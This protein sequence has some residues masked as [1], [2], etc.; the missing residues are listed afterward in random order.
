MFFLF[1]LSLSSGATLS[2]T[3]FFHVQTGWTFFFF[4]V[5][6]EFHNKIVQHNRIYRPVFFFSHL[7]VT[8]ALYATLIVLRSIKR[9][10]GKIGG[11]KRAKVHKT[12]HKSVG[13]R[14]DIFFAL[15]SVEQGFLKGRHDTEIHRILAEGHDIPTV[16]Q[17]NFLSE[18]AA[19]QLRGRR[20]A[21]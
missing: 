8:P 21:S 11:K 10:G 14:P 9:R 16:I 4:V 19:D 18:I 3:G 20:S 12:F 17:R 5:G 1:Y 13:S 2:T 7:H 6:R 15:R